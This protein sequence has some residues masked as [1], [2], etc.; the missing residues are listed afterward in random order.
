MIS[1]EELSRLVDTQ[2]WWVRLRG[3]VRICLLNVK[4]KDKQTFTAKFLPCAR[5]STV[6][7]IPYSQILGVDKPRA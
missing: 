2:E 6:Y 7:N 5:N 1:F 4:D 3:D